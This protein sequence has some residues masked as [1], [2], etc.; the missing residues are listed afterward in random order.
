M[1]DDQQQRASFNDPISGDRAERLAAD[2]GHQKSR[3][4]IQEVVKDYV[5]STEFADKVEGIMLKALEADPARNKLKEWAVDI[6]QKEIGSDA[7]QTKLTER[8]DARIEET[9]KSRSW[10]NKTFWIPTSIATIAAIAAVV[11]I[12][13]K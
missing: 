7:A 2:L 10:R 4:A 8:V 9:L 6:A 11:A 12:F 13:V 1:P 3:I 5:G